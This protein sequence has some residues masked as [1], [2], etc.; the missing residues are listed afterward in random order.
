MWLRSLWLYKDQPVNELY[1]G[2]FVTSDSGYIYFRKDGDSDKVGI[3]V[4]FKI[5]YSDD[6]GFL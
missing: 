2:C 1:S 6:T 4:I 5:Y 3:M